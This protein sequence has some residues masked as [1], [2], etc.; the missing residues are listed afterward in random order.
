MVERVS[1]KDEVEGPIP[2]MPTGGRADNKA[3]NPGITGFLFVKIA[4]G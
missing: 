2:S 4:Y 3:K 1:D